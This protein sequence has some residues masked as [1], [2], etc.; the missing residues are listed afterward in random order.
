M[1]GSCSGL[2]EHTRIQFGGNLLLPFGK[3]LALA[4]TIR[5]AGLIVVHKKA[6]T[7]T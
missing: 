1:P 4:A 3:R 7:V 5:I 6:M 2:K